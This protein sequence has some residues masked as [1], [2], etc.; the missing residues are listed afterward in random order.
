MDQ[1]PAEY[2][3]KLEGFFIDYDACIRPREIVFRSELINDMQQEQRRI[4][5]WNETLSR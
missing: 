2:Y 4:L 1:C 3:D 5:L